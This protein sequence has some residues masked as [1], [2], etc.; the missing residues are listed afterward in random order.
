MNNDRT[1]RDRA[2]P[3]RVRV[4]QLKRLN[5]GCAVFNISDAL[6]RIGDARREIQRLDYIAAVIVH[7]LVHSAEFGVHYLT[8]MARAIRK[9]TLKLGTTKLVVRN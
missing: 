2:P 3:Y 8:S 7:V 5:S 9:G 1:S 4:V 6:V